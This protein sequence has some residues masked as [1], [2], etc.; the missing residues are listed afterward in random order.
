M[1]L[2]V[3]FLA[4]NF[5]TYFCYQGVYCIC[6][7]NTV[8]GGGMEARD[9]IHHWRGKTSDLDPHWLYADPDPQNLANA[10]PGQ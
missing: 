4:F 9:D 1:K 8:L 2:N 7:A 10:D 3:I 5:L 6:Y